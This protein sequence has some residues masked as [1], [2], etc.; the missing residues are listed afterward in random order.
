MRRVWPG[1]VVATGLVIVGG[2]YVAAGGA[3]VRVDSYRLARDSTIVVEAERGTGDWVRLTDLEESDTQVR[4][5]VKRV[6]IPFF[7]RTGVGIP[8]YFT[9]DLEQPLGDRVVEDGFG[10]VLHRP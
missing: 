10:D 3:P 8:V 9:I 5:T 4:V 2:T 6:S 1:V 7:G